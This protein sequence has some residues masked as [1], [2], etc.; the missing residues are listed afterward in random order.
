MGDYKKVRD[1]NPKSLL[2]WSYA[3]YQQVLD[4]GVFD[5]HIRLFGNTILRIKFEKSSVCKVNMI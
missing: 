3:L 4:M 5:T 2:H 1:V